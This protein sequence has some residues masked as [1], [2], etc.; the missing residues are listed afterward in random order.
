MNK[1]L[2]TLPTQNVM[3]INDS[4][5]KAFSSHIRRWSSNVGQDHV[6]SDEQS[7][8]M[9]FAVVSTSMS[10]ALGIVFGEVLFSSSRTRYLFFFSTTFFTMNAL[11]GSLT[12]WRYLYRHLS[13]FLIPPVFF[14][15]ARSKEGF[16]E[17]RSC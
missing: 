4:N 1:K 13:R 11:V 17:I 5:K 2:I 16:G 12:D 6:G 15:L 9:G 3:L 14:Q 7:L 8:N 10:G